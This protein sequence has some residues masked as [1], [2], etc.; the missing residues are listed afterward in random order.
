MGTIVNAISVIAGGMIGL[1]IRRGLPKKV[2][3]TAMKLLGLAV[4][5]V[6][7]EGVIT[8]MVTV[9]ADGRLSAD[10]SLLLIASMVV[11]GVLGELCDIDAAL[12]RGGKA[13]EAKF[14]KEGF[15]KGFINASLIFCVGAMA[16]IGALNDGLTGDP[17]VLF[18]KSAL[19][20]ICSII[21]GSTLGFGVVFAFIPVL[22]YQGSITLLAGV[23]APVVSG[24]M[25]NAICMVG[26]TIVMCIGINFLEFTN[27]RT[28]NLLP[29]LLVPVVYTLA[30]PHVARFFD[31]VRQMF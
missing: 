20:F 12:V 5:L 8:S 30:Q 29:A 7:I 21:L 10:G 18:I 3:E 4:F 31:Q 25:L 2:E 23:L 28:A 17:S 24:P 13:I 19:D 9:G 16:I 14:G 1:L 26:Y 27:I 15:A 22:A 6:G 11:G